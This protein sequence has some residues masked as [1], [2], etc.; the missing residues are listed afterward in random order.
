MKRELLLAAGLLAACSPIEEETETEA[1]GEAQQ[2]ICFGDEPPSGFT[3]S[4]ERS[5]DGAHNAVRS[6]GFHGPDPC[7]FYSMGVDTSPDRAKWV[8]VQYATEGACSDAAPVAQQAFVW[9][10]YGSGIFS[11]WDRQEMPMDGDDD[12][13]TCV[14]SG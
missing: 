13:E 1:V 9:T 3:P 14:R 7:S 11:I 5:L 8:T 6:D 4:V 12:G 10:R 2:A